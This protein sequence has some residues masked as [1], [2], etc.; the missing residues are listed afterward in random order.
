MTREKGKRPRVR[1]RLVENQDKFNDV[2]DE[3]KK[4]L[5]TATKASKYFIAFAKAKGVDISD[6]DWLNRKSNL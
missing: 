1:E 4:M 6:S 5:K 3:S 2:M